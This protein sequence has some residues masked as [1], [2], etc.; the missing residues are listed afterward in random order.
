MAS[1]IR[2]VCS[3]WSNDSWR[4]TK[5]TWAV[6]GRLDVIVNDNGDVVLQVFRNDLTARP[7]S[8]PAVWLPVAGMAEFIDD[9]LGINSGAQP[10][11]AGRAGF[12]FACS[13]VSR[14][15]YF[16]HLEIWRQL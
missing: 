10:L 1:R 5:R 6:T 9:H 13:D 14:R 8:A 11:T 4:W 12:G 15:A 3:Q 16:D 2:T 7:L